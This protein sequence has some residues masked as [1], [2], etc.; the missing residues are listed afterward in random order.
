[1]IDTDDRQFLIP[2]ESL[3]SVIWQ[4]KAAKVLTDRIVEDLRGD[5]IKID[6]N[7]SLIELQRVA[8]LAKCTARCIAPTL[9]AAIDLLLEANALNSGTKPEE[10]T[11]LEA[12]APRPGP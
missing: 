6:G 5:E 11:L 12:A 7:Q 9:Q 1:M 10:D 2:A 8:D 3:D 4:I